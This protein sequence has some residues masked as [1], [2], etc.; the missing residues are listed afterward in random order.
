MANSQQDN[1]AV[2][3]NSEPIPAQSEMAAMI[4]IIERAARDPSVDID[5]LQRL[6]DMQER[7]VQRNAATAYAAA[8][9]DMQPDLPVI[10]ERGKI[11]IGRGKPQSYA[12]WEDINETIKPVLAKHGFSLSFRTGQEDGKIIVTGILSHRE[13]HSER[14]TMHLPT[15]TSGS[16]NAVQAVGSSTSYGKRYTAAA[17][18]NLTSRG[19]DDDG[20]AGGSAG[21]ITEEQLMQLVELADE[22]GADKIAFC[23]YFNIESLA[24]IQ[25]KDFPRAVAALNRKRAK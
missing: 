20:L 4:H 5:K 24:A 1:L 13:G 14:T 9:S 15:D 18:L 7:I 3:G 16:K 23:K 11:D 10:T 8:L 17:L 21:K 25:A 2:V 19:E 12:L 22:V 6:M